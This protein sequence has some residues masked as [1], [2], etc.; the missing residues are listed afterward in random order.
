MLGI[1]ASTCAQVQLTPSF[2]RQPARIE[3]GFPW[4]DDVD[5]GEGVSKAWVALVADD[6]QAAFRRALG[7]GAS[8]GVE[9]AARPWGQVFGYG[10]DLNGAALSLFAS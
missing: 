3:T 7:A 5:H 6:V 9:P 10:C 2:A 4:Y 8:A 1:G